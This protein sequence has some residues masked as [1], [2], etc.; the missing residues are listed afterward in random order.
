MPLAVM[1]GDGLA[2]EIPEAAYDA[3]LEACKHNLHGRI[4]WPKGWTPLSVA[5]LKEKLSLI[6]KDLARWGIISLGKGFFEF[7]FSSLEDVRRVRSIPSW[8]LNPGMLKLF[9]WTKDFN[10]KMQHNTSVQVWVRIYGLGQEYWQKSI[11]FTIASSLG[12]PIC[13]DSVTAKP[14]HERTFGQFA[15]VLVDIDLLQPLRYKLLVERKGFAFFVELDY[16]HIPEFCS[17]CKIIGHNVDNC[18]R[19]A[20]EEELK[21]DKD[22]NVKKKQIAEPRK[23]FVPTKDVRPQQSK[24]IEI[25]NE[26]KD[27]INVED[28]SNKTQEVF[29]EGNDIDNRTIN[30]NEPIVSKE[31][32]NTSEKIDVSNTSQEKVVEHSLSPRAVLNAQDKLLEEELNDKNTTE[33]E[34]SVSASSSQVSFVKDSH[35][36]VINDDISTLNADLSQTPDR[37]LHD[38]AFLKESW[39]NMADAKAE[40]HFTLKD[41]SQNVEK[42]ATEDGFQVHL[43]RGQ[44][45]ANKKLNKSRDFN[46]IIGAHEYRGRLS[47][48]RLPMNEF[49]AWTDSFNLIHL[50]THGAE[51]TWNN[52]RGGFRHTEKRLDRAICNHAWMDL[53]NVSSVSTLIRHKSDH[54]PLLLEV[55]L[56]SLSLASSFKFMKMWSSDPNCKNIVLDCWNTDVTGC[57]MFVLSKK[58]KI[59]KD[60]LK[61]WNKECFGNVHEYVKTAEQRLQQI[62][63]QIQNSGHSDALLEEQKLA[64]IS[65]EDALNR[66]EAFWQEKANLNWHLE[67]DRNTKF[68]HRT[69]KIKS[70]TKYINSLQD[71]DRDSLLVE[72]VIPTLVTDEINALMTILPSHD[73]IKVAVFALNKDSAPGPDG[74]GAFFY[75]HYWD[76]V[77]NDVINAVLEFFTTSWILPGFNSNIIALL[78][79]SPEAYSIDQY[80]PIAMANFKFKVISKIIAD[81]LASI[82]PSLISEEQKGF[83][84]DRNI[85]DCL[86]TA[87][88][89]A[90]LLQ[91]RPLEGDPLSPLLFC[92][93]EDVLSRSISK[94]VL[95][96]RLNLIKGTRKFNVPSHSFYADDLMIF[97]KGNLAGLKALKDLFGRYANESG[98]VI[99]NSKSTIFSG[100]ITPGRLAIISQLLNFKL[101]SLPFNY[102]GVPIFK[103]KPKVCHLQPIADKI[104]LKLSAWKASLLSIAGRVQLVRAV[105]QSMLVYSITLYCWPVTLLK[106]IEKWVRNF[107]WSGD[108]EKRKLVTT[109]WKKLCRPLSQ[110]GLNLKSLTNL[111]KATN[112]NLCWTIL[113]SNNSWA[114]L[115]RDRVIRNRKIIQHHIFSSIWSS[116]KDEFE[117]IM[118]NSVW[119]LGNGEDINF[120][121]DNWCGIPLAEQLNIPFHIRQ[122]LCSTVSDYL[123]NGL[124]SIPLHLSLAYPTLSSIVQQISIPL[125]PSHDKLLWKHTDSG[126]LQLKDAYLFKIQQFQDLHWAKT[127]WSP[128]IPPS[129]SLLAWRLMHDKVPTDDNLILRGCSIVS[130]CSLCNKHVESSFHIFFDCEFAIKLWSWLAGC[131]NVT[132][133]FT[134]MEDMWKLCDLNWSPQSKITL[135]ATIINLLNSIWLARNDARFNNKSPS[136]RTTISI[137]IASTALTGNNTCKPSSNSLRDFAFLKRFRV[138]IH[139]PK[140]QIIKE[141]SWEPPLLHWIKCNIDGAACE[142]SSIASC[143]GIFRNSS[144]DFVY[145]FAEPLGVTS[146]YFA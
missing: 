43:S 130:M 78:P 110:G 138:N 131:V 125:D 80:K 133:Q 73:E 114:K 136:W 57:P 25:I 7:T 70:S 1:K 20:K 42:P 74:F 107:I 104:K 4:L 79:K 122:F 81:R 5:A 54:F 37:V 28:S 142:N 95:D 120:W 119:L 60:K 128:D 112:L 68:F 132:L 38:M 72:E 44:K 100:S 127:I 52:G 101:G 35:N 109:S 89:A 65:F 18:K 63:E 59:L 105:I 48:A 90:N 82:M 103:G 32:E 39:A 94:L 106:D 146:A 102:L 58:L 36:L 77:K 14:M 91:T 31:Q 84:H 69:A 19:W 9:A 45:K 64:N 49:Q 15:R 76:I 144:A 139:H 53:C 21:T 51:F 92:L 40:A 85:K 24:P 16:E 115:I 83:I 61:I 23:V 10:P 121:N 129:K 97:C 134:S 117:I 30:N 2:I 87:S 12:T 66:Q 135:T 98:Q 71:G 143:G 55:Q 46:V 86:C 111:N 29:A 17:S 141:V 3:G 145:G 88:E 56:S 116:V 22:N 8:N 126:D 33:A 99:N 96:G 137:I 123:V 47:P 34:L 62:Q 75:Q 27:V 67:G 6:W 11:L 13:I 124:W 108:M 113:N 140:A 26:E 93:A 41:S 118:D 50:P